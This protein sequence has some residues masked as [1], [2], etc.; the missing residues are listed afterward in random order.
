MSSDV[1]N[2]LIEHDQESGKTTRVA[3]VVAHPDD[4]ILWAGGLL[5]SHPEWAT[6]ILTLCRREDPDRAPKFRK[7]LGLLHSEGAMGNLDDG[8]NQFPLS[9]QRVQ[10]AIL[11][12]LPKQEYDLL[13]TH[14][15]QGEYTWHRRHGEVSLAV[16][17]LWRDGQIRAQSMWQFAYEDGGGTYAPRPQKEASTEI[18]LSD[19]VWKR[20]YD[21]ITKVYGFDETS[22]EARAV[23]RV[24]AFHCFTDPG[25][26]HLL[27]NDGQVLSR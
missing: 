18:P 23:S 22:W 26:I 3:V 2:T 11:S 5:L 7:V 27:A 17:E 6:F 20:K 14:A 25:S 4:E 9:S 15:P 12:L 10:D 21:L 13:L 1:M 24:E 19:P 8:P 16:R